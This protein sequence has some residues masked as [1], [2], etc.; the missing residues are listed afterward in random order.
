MIAIIDYGVGNLFSLK[1]SLKQ[2]GLEAV[3]TAD[4]DTIRKADRLILPGVGAFADA[5]A[6]LEATGL[7]PVMKEEAEKKPLLGICLGMQLLFEKS[8]EYGEHEGLGFVKGEVCPLEPD[9]A[10]KSLK[11]PQIGWNALHIVKDDPL[12]KYI[13]EAKVYV[14]VMGREDGPKPAIEALNRAAGHVRTEVSKKM[15]IRKAPR[16]IF[17]EDDGAAY[18]AHINELLRTLNVNGDAD[19]EASAPEE[20]EE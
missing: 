2:L 17:V 5:M 9:L 1:S 19:T 4:A 7:V 13:R 11:V 8:Y 16:F 3:V 15:H 14:S 10:D 18:A 12:F 6:K 20:T